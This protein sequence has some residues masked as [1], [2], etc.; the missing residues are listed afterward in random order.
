MLSFATLE[1]NKLV[2][3]SINVM[4]TL[5]IKNGPT[6]FGF[7]LRCD[8]HPLVPRSMWSK[9]WHFSIKMMFP[10][11]ETLINQLISVLSDLYSSFFPT[12]TQLVTNNIKKI[13]FKKITFAERKSKQPPWPVG[14]V[15]LPIKYYLFSTLWSLKTFKKYRIAKNN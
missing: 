1:I 14:C 12:L 6:F 8:F 13:N 4:K 3:S 10:A 5:N 15:I 7:F 2:P 11:F 9:A